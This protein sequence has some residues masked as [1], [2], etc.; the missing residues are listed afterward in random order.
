[1]KSVSRARKIG[2]DTRD[3]FAENATPGKETLA[4][5]ASWA[6]GALLIDMGVVPS[7]RELEATQ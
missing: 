4:Q 7:G 5:V 1:M 3:R 6:M 2:Y